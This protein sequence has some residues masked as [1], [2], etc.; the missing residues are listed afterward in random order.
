MLVLP[1]LLLISSPRWL[2][3]QLLIDAFRPVFGD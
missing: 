3:A 2:D 1:V